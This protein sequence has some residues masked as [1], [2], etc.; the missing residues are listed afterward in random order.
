MEEIIKEYG[1]SIL[2]SIAGIFF[3]GTSLAFL[4][5]IYHM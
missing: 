2:Y 5:L 4:A 1:L 3:V